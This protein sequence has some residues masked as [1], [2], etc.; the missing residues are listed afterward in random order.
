MEYLHKLKRC[1]KILNGIHLDSEKLDP[2]DEADGALDYRRTLLFL[3]QLLQLSHELLLHGRKPVRKKKERKEENNIYMKAYPQ[4]LAQ[5][6][7]LHMLWK[8]P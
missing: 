5:N 1:L 7:I 2:H 6:S 8:Q 4:A 3:P